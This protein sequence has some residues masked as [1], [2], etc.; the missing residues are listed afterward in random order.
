MAD[1]TAVCSD[2]KRPAVF[3]AERRVVSAAARPR[4]QCV[5][6]ARHR[7]EGGLA[8]DV[9]P[10]GRLYLCIAGRERGERLVWCGLRAGGNGRRTPIRR[11]TAPVGPVGFPAGRR[12]GDRSQNEQFTAAPALVW[13]AV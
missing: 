4:L 9:A 3:F 7:A 5:H 11:N 8:L 10:A 12:T 6:P 13:G 1:R 2:P